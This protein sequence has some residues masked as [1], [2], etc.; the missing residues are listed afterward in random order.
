MKS[1]LGK[2]SNSSPNAF[3]LS[4]VANWFSFKF[5]CYAGYFAFDIELTCFE[6]VPDPPDLASD[7]LWDPTDLP[8]A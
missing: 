8:F 4:G 7:V 3:T 6:G 2:P 5:C 1:F